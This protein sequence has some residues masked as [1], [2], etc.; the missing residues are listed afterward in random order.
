MIDIFGDGPEGNPDSD[1]SLTTSLVPADIGTL[2]SRERCVLGGLILNNDE[3]TSAWRSAT[4]FIPDAEEVLFSDRRHRVLA[5]GLLQMGSK[6]IP[7]DFQTLFSR[8]VKAK[9]LELAGGPAYVAEHT[10][11]WWCPTNCRWHIEQLVDQ[12]RETQ[13]VEL[14][15]KLA[16]GA[17]SPGELN[18]VITSVR[19]KMEG[20]LKAESGFEVPN[21]NEASEAI[22]RMISK[23]TES[24][25][26]V[27]FYWPDLQRK[28]GGMRRGKQTYLSAPPGVGKT[29]FALSQ[30]VFS[31]KALNLVVCMF[32]MESEKDETFVRFAQQNYAVD[33]RNV[34]QGE[35]LRDDIKNLTRA[36]TEWGSLSNRLFVFRTGNI[37]GDGV[38]A[39]LQKWKSATGL[40][41]DLLIID[42]LS[43]M[44]S[45]IPKVPDSDYH[46][47]AANSKRLAEIGFAMN[48]ATV[49]L[50]QPPKEYYAGKT[51][52]ARP[53][54]G[55]LKGA[56]D[57]GQTAKLVIFLHYQPHARQS[58]AVSCGE[59]VIAKNN[60]GGEATIPTIYVQPATLHLENNGHGLRGYEDLISKYGGINDDK[61]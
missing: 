51:V 61:H 25:S 45:S 42:N 15:I 30:A 10:L 14:G 54:L 3:S 13:A 40:E 47:I 48:C 6:R 21:L 20:L 2:L 46:A 39:E 35:L 7:V 44:K 11:H 22:E 26:S 60:N 58:R 18:E 37:S 57:M 32:L 28:T 23:D 36:A 59:F 24:I 55:D 27:R 17:R 41:C 12:W 29:A 49:V 34:T 33:G 16:Y 9:K 8:L 5:R 1:R 19:R 4:G 38:D 56:G 53:T 31:A 52:L 50:V 43:T